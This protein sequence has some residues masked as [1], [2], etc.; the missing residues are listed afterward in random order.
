MTPAWVQTRAEMRAQEG[1]RR[2][3][4]GRVLKCLRLRARFSQGQ[5]GSLVGLSAG[6]IDKIEEGDAEIPM[7]GFER[8]AQAFAVEPLELREMKLWFYNRLT[9]SVQC[10][11]L[12]PRLVRE[13]IGRQSP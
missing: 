8:F 6:Y 7:D 1:L 2:Q 4:A 12:P 13:T 9:Y 3:A 10:G 5:L 11:D